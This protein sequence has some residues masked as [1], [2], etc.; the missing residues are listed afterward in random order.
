M[1][2]DKRIKIIRLSLVGTFKSGAPHALLK[3]LMQNVKRIA[4]GKRE[5]YGT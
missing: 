5:I 1:K 3:A 2:D 4:Q